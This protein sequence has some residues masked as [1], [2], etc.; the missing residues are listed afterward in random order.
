MDF[1]S[2]NRIGKQGPSHRERTE[3]RIAWLYIV[4]MLLLFTL[5]CIFMVPVPGVVL[6]LSATLYALS[7]P[8]ERMIVT[9]IS[10]IPFSIGFQYR[11]LIL[12]CIASHLFL[13][14]ASLQKSSLLVI[15]FLLTWEALHCLIGEFSAVAWLRNFAEFLFLMVLLSMDLR[16]FSYQRI[17]R[18]FA[19]S[20]I[21]ICVIMLWMQLERNNYQLLRMLYSGTGFFRFGGN[22]LEDA[23][24]AFN[25][26]PNG[27]GMICNSATAGIIILYK[28]SEHNK[29]DLVFMTLLILFGCMTLS[30]TYFLVLSLIIMSILFIDRKENFLRNLRILLIL[31][32]V[33]LLIAWQLPE[34]FSSVW[35]RWTGANALSQRDILL[36][37]YLKHILSSPSHF[38]F[39]TGVQD[40]SDKIFDIYGY[41]YDV[42][43][44]FLQE[45]WCVWG[46]VGIIAMGYLFYHMVRRSKFCSGIDK[47]SY[48]FLPFIV[49]L[50]SCMAGQLVTIG[51]NLL[52]LIFAYLC[53]CIPA[54]QQTK[55]EEIS[56]EQTAQ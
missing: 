53:M 48:H 50:C 38:L 42:P 23:Q 26:N 13:N 14:R 45:I 27:L 43:H 16:E 5:K 54:V 52:L 2:V 40:L 8:K 19:V 15:F 49:L 41:Q 11:Y 9:I 20:T 24:L 29:L 37:F 21:G 3:G 18:V 35:R 36:T 25:F 17:I 22:N 47:R 44:N 31:V 30:K 10:C 4:W 34:I 56:A 51:R 39:G 12:I 32:L 46:L 55:H 33:I 6:L 1:I 7:G 28:R